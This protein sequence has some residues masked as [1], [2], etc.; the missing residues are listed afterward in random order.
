MEVIIEDG[1]EDKVVFITGQQII[2]ITKSGAVEI[3]DM[4]VMR[5]G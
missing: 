2:N 4:E 3:T 1:C 5:E